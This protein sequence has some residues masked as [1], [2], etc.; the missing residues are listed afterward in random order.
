VKAL[1]L[2]PN[3]H[4]PMGFVMPDANKR[5]LV[6]LASSHGIPIIEDDVYGDLQHRGPRPHTLKARE[7][8]G[9]VLYCSSFSKNIAP[10][11]RVGYI[12]AGKWQGRVAALKRSQTGPNANLPAEAIA[13]FIK[14]G[15]YDRYMRSFRESLRQQ[16]GLMSEAVAHS[17]P[18]G[19]RLSR[20]EGGYILW[21]ELPAQVDSLGLVRQA[22]AAGIT[23]APGPLFSTDG[24]YRNFLR[25]NCGVRWGPAIERAVGVLGHLVRG[26]A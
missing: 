10:G 19:I 9:N 8:D 18:E 1:L 11:Y 3:F 24:G 4:N 21:C 14:N 7:V 25:I 12:I 5:E 22:S 13:E 15:G 6:R 20:P 16:V 2:V 23:V 26:A 17:F